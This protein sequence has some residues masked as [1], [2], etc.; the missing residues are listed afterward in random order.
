MT[1]KTGFINQICSLGDVIFTN[2]FNENVNL[3]SLI[4]G[5]WNMFNAL[6]HYFYYRWSVFDK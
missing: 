2:T 1:G 4:G 5:I 6:K 3:V